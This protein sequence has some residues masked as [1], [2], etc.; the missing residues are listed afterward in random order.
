MRNK[1]SFTEL[2]KNVY[3][4]GLTRLCYKRARLI[5]RPVYIRGK[6]SL[7]GAR[8]LTTGR[9]CRLDLDGSRETLYIGDHCEFGD[10]MHIVA[11]SKVV[12]GDHVL[13]ASKVFISDTD[14][15]SYSRMEQDAP[16]VPPGDRKL[17]SRQVRIGDRVWLGENVVVLAGVEIGCGCII[18][19][20]SVVSQ[21]IP[22]N[23]IAAG[24][25]A[26]VIKRWD[27]EQGLWIRESHKSE[28]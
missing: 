24:I 15:G 9:M 12:I 10:Y 6:K 5:R 1:Y 23:C 21:S 20:G 17:Y 2:I 7:A 11:H 18:G 3:S 13:A 27:E 16:S 25:P 19:A 22:A 28:G 14:H 26:R 4:Y 8:G